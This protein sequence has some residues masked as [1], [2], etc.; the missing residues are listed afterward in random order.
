MNSVRRITTT[1]EYHGL[2]NIEKAHKLIEEK[3]AGVR[4]VCRVLGV[5]AGQLTRAKKAKA[6]SKQIGVN[7]R[8]KILGEEGEAMLVNAIDEARKK[9]EPMNYHEVKNK[10]S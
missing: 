5:N 4:E 3:Q 10:V 6:E 7:G 9:K 8:P 2:S 1:Q